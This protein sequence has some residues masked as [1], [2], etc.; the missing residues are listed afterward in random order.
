MDPDPELG[1]GPRRDSEDGINAQPHHP[2]LV[3]SPATSKKVQLVD[4]H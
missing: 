3:P 4:I 2:M 1:S